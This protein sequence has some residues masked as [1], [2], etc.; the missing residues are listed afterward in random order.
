MCDK[1]RLFECFSF[2]GI[3]RDDGLAFTSMKNKNDVDSWF[4]RFQKKISELSN[5]NVEFEMVKW[6]EKETLNFL[7]I[8]MYWNDD[9]ELQFQV[10]RKPNQKLKYLNFS[11]TH[12]KAMKAAVPDGVMKR[13]ARLTSRSDKL[14]KSKI[15][16]IYPDHAQA[17]KKAKL[18]PNDSFFPTFGKLWEKQDAP[19]P[20]ST[21]S[22]S[23]RK[24]DSKRTIF[25]CLGASKTFKTPIWAIIRDL[26][27]LYNLGWLRV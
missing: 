10:Y 22:N 27:G 26:K 16:E 23:K 12:T 11:S 25:F 15:S 14:V 24:L 13:L 20:K 17:L 9:E 8:S 7:D 3:Y 5:N 4:T 19:L 21:R 18:V 6:S 2:R 1:E